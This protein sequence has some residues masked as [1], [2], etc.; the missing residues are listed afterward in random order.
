MHYIVKHAVNAET[1][2]QFFFVWLNVNVGRPAPQCVNEE[3]VDQ[4]HDWRIFAH[5]CEAGEIDLFVFF[6][7][8]DFAGQ[9]LLIEVEIVE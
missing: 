7:D 9:G 1:N 3:D 5:A 4:T 2:A 8:L 6:E